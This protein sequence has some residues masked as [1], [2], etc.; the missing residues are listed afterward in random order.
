M[1]WI[2]V[3]K[4]SPNFFNFVHFNNFIRPGQ[5]FNF[6]N[7]MF[8]FWSL[9]Y[10]SI[11]KGKQINCEISTFYVFSSNCCLPLVFHSPPSFFLFFFEVK[12]N[13]GGQ[14][15]FLEEKMFKSKQ[16]FFGRSIHLVSSQKIWRLIWEI[17]C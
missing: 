17:F 8:I 11:F 16:K 7:G 4:K 5:N 3:S 1:W 15:L 6:W 13:D 14:K 10:F 2:W 12:Q 9:Y